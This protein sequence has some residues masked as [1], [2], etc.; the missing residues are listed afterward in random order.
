MTP[1]VVVVGAAARDLA[2]DDPRGWRLGGGVTYSALLTARL[3]LP[4]GALVGVDAA[5]ERAAELDLL[6]EAGVEVHTVL[7]PRGPVFENVERPE[8]RLQRSGGPSDPV[9]VTAIPAGWADAPG[10]LLVPV[11]AELPDAWADAPRSDATVAV[12][13]QGLL[14]ELTPD[15][16]VRHVA[17]SPSPILGRADLVGISR[18]DVEPDLPLALLTGHLKRGATLVVTQGDRGGVVLE[19]GRTDDRRLRHYPALRS[20]A[21]V[22]PTGAGDV[23]LA[24]LAAARIEP[25]LVGGRIAAG[26]DLLLA[27]A[28]AS[29]VIE[30]IGLHGVPD[31]DA[32]RDR[33]REVSRRRGDHRADRR[34]ADRSSLAPEA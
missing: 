9:P 21:V 17:P 33:I 12:G 14:R 18:D 23:F 26:H 22:D 34:E 4:T 30:G 25:R 28:A 5:S 32:V 8:G 24:A 11:A 29:L 20:H 27:A 2:T 6:R 7:L 13:W 15:A 16:P 19:A 10:W 31:R 1:Q 3:G